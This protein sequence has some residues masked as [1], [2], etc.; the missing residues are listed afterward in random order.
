MPERSSVPAPAKA[1]D[2]FAPLIGPPMVSVPAFT[3]IVGLLD[4]ATAAVPKFSG[5]DPLKVKLPPIKMPPPPTF[6]VIGAPLVLSI[7]PPVIW[8]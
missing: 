8:K 1:S 3:V 4:K 6:R 2:W 7:A 5:L